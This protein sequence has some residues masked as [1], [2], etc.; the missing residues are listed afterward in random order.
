MPAAASAEPP[1]A[2]AL[3]AAF[4]RHEAFTVGLEEELMLLDSETLDLAPRV[5]DALTVLEGDPRFVR[6][7]PAAQLEIVLPPEG[8]VG[9]AAGALRRA[10]HDLAAALRPL[11]LRA[12]GAGL[13]PFAPEE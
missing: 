6:E 4:D 1:A 3:R 12:A 11:G 9:A 8:A 10:R 2:G 5:D 7:L 13:H